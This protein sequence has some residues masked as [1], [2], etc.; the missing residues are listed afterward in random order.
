MVDR[1]DEGRQRMPKRMERHESP[2]GPTED[3]SGDD[4]SRNLLPSLMR[5]SMSGDAAES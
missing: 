4:S 2:R 3:R 5:S 1:L